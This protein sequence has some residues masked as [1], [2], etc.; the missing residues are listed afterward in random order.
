MRTIILSLCCLL[1]FIGVAQ[2]ET[3]TK[4]DISLDIGNYSASLA[5]PSFQAFHPGARLGMHYQ[6]NENPNFQLT[7]SV[8][9]G[10]FSHPLYQQAISIYTETAFEWH[11]NNGLYIRPL[12]LGGGYLISIGSFPTLDWDEQTQS[13]IENKVPIR[14]QWMISLGSEMGYQLDFG[15][16]PTLY[17]AYRLLV[18]G[19]VVQ[20]TVP[21]IA[22]SP[23]MIGVRLPFVKP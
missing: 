11:L 6:W 7:Q 14:N 19:V 9:L 20:S 3:L 15:P 17:A 18:H 4:W 22:Y 1:P 2:E 8:Y 13:Y 12:S 21:V 16:K 5:V 10:Y 23:L